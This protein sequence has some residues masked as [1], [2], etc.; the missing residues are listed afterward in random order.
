MNDRTDPGRRAV[1]TLAASV[2]PPGPPRGLRAGRAVRPVPALAVVTL[3]VGGI[4]LAA[5]WA[6]RDGEE[7]PAASDAAATVVV[8]H[9][10]VRGRPVQARVEELPA[11]GA[12]VVTIAEERSSSGA[13]TAKPGDDS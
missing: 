13:S 10:R 4:A 12:V 6:L 8:E 11:A 3:I 1:D 5:W 9:L 2:K 7:L